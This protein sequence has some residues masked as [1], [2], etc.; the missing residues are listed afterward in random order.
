MFALWCCV[1]TTPIPPPAAWPAAG[2]ALPASAAAVRQRGF[3]FE[4]RCHKL[5]LTRV[6]HGF[7]SPCCPQI[8]MAVDENSLPQPSSAQQRFVAALQVGGWVL[9]VAC[10]TAARLHLQLC[11]AQCERCPLWTGPHALTA[12]PPPLLL[13]CRSAG[14]AAGRGSGWAGGGGRRAPMGVSWDRRGA[15]SRSGAGRCQPH[16]LEECAR[17]GELPACCPAKRLL[18][19]TRRTLC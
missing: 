18:L 19:H 4:S 14:Y 2:H 1:Q 15:G 12:R 6:L 17:P 11:W 16:V 10:L 7:R 13:R 9:L 5:A 8:C 3:A